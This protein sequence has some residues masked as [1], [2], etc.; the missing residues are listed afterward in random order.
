M[1]NKPGADQP[2]PGGPGGAKANFVILAHAEAEDMVSED[3]GL[4]DGINEMNGGNR[5]NDNEYYSISGV[6][7]S[8][9]S[10]GIY[11]LNGKKVIVK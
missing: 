2:G 5:M 8:N 4:V 3:A 1:T 9:P 6:K 10:K 7:V 11:I